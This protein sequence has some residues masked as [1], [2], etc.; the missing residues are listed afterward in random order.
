MLGSREEHT[1]NAAGSPNFVGTGRGRVGSPRR[2]RRSGSIS[3]E[4]AIPLDDAHT[5]AL[6]LP[7]GRFFM[8]RIRNKVRRGLSIP[9]HLSISSSF[10]K[11]GRPF[12]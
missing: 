5:C 9:G 10:R 1:G 12:L 11:I 3:P 8:P 7:R 6:Q 2:Y 4:P